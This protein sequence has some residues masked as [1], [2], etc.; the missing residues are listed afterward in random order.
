MAGSPPYIHV[1]GQTNEFIFNP[2]SI[3]SPSCE[4]NLWDYQVIWATPSLIS[5]L[6][7]AVDPSTNKI[8]ATSLP[9]EAGNY[10]L[11]EGDYTFTLRSTLPNGQ[12]SEFDFV[13]RI[14]SN[15]CTVTAPTV[16]QK[17]FL[18]GDAAMTF[19]VDDFAS[20]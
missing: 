12:Y 16:L 6:S 2:P 8:K 17:T 10:N 14:E 15:I 5:N 19:T 4:A 20:K 13:I 3:T 9:D 11:A 18:I 1:Y 7:I